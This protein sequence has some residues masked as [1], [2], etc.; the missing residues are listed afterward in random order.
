MSE[1][2]EVDPPEGSNSREPKNETAVLTMGI[3]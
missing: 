1:K 3:C 2:I